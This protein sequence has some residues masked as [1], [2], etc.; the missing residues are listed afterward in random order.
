MKTLIRHF[1]IGDA[2][3]T[4]SR[5]LSSASRNVLGGRVFNSTWGISGS[6]RCFTALVQ[7]FKSR[8]KKRKVFFTDALNAC[9]KCI[10]VQRDMYRA[11][12]ELSVIF[13]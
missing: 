9:N 12:T 10:R 4:G 8:G 1:A 11:V 3:E 7:I 5:C 2:R 6:L 13:Q